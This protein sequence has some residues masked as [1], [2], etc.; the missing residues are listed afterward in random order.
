MIVTI[1]SSG[2]KPDTPSVVTGSTKLGTVAATGGT[3]TT[4]TSG[5]TQWSLHQFDSTGVINFSSG[6]PIEYIIV[7]GGGGGAEGGVGAGAGAVVTGTTTVS[8]GNYAITVGG[9]GGGQEG[10]WYYGNTV[11]NGQPSSAFSQTADGGQSGGN[12]GNGRTPGASFQSGFSNT[13][14]GGGGGSA[15][16][17]NPGSFPRQGGSGGSGDDISAFLGQ[18]GGTTYKGGGGGGSGFWAN[19]W[20]NESILGGAG[21]LGGGGLS[22]GVGAVGGGYV[23]PQT[24]RGATNSGGGGAT[25]AGRMG[26]PTD[27]GARGA[28]GGSGIVY[29]R[30]ALSSQTTAEV[31]FVEPTFK[32]KSGVA[33]YRVKSNTNVQTLGDNSPIEVTGLTPGQNYNFTVTTVADSGMESD[34]SAASNTFQLGIAPGAPTIGTATA[35]NSAGNYNRATV[36]F[37]P[38]TSGTGTTTYTAT[39][40][41]G[42]FTASNT[43]GDPITVT[44]L[45]VGVSYTFTVTASNSFGANTSG[46]SNSIVANGI[47]PAP[48]LNSVSA[49]YSRASLSW[50]AAAGATS[51]IAYAVASGYTTRTATTSGTSVTISSLST[52]VTYTFYVVASNAAGSSGNSNSLTEF[53]DVPCPAGTYV[54][55]IQYPGEGTTC[56]YDRRCDGDGGIGLYYVGGGC[57]VCCSSG[58][59]VGAYCAGCSPCLNNDEGGCP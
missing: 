49:S 8:P 33:R 36:S 19:D 46:Q 56:T 52:N 45:E 35:G 32:G 37:T 57:N 23:I 42:G 44:S 2:G 1:G 12:S 47:P 26:Q 15:A 24:A 16:N 39:S 28:N 7:G 6:G 27:G 29:V 22:P 53:T 34:E 50:S 54:N 20:G 11:S 58:R 18:S 31:G 14:S 48:V 43:T 38:G 17:G 10:W 3:K 55:T 13:V 9:G 4:I 40:I 30:Y 21:G 51:Y 59:V 5:G 25:A 41:P